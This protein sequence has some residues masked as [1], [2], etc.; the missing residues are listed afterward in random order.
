[1]RQQ[2]S[3]FFEWVRPR[4]APDALEATWLDVAQR[5]P[6]LVAILDPGGGGTG[7]SVLSD[8]LS[9][10]AST[11]NKLVQAFIAERGRGRAGRHAVRAD[12]LLPAARRR[13][14]AQPALHHVAAVGRAGGRHRRS[15][16]AHRQRRA[17]VHGAGAPGAGARG[18]GRLRSV[19]G[20][21]PAVVERD[22]RLRRADPDPGLAP[23]PGSRRRSTCSSRARREGRS[24]CCCTAC[25]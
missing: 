19:R 20:A 21:G 18:A 13:R 9:R 7:V 6:L 1:M 23:R 16:D 10:L 12:G 22:G 5:Y 15:P 11:A 8:G 17:A 3:A 24:A 4:L 25:S 2:A 14:A